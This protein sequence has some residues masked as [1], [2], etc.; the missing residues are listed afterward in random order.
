MFQHV[1]KSIWLG[2]LFSAIALGTVSGIA[3]PQNAFDITAVLIFGWLIPLLATSSDL[4]FNFNYVSP[5][6]TP[7]WLELL[8][9]FY[10]P[11]VAL[12][13]AACVVWTLRRT[14]KRL[15]ALLIAGLLA[16]ASTLVCML[17]GL[18]APSLNS[19][20]TYYSVALAGAVWLNLLFSAVLGWGAGYLI[21]RRGCRMHSKK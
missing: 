12:V 15:D 9:S 18:V 8:T 10:Y 13:M 20:G 19:N 11:L 6:H 3:F 4:N 5:S 7:M 16:C 21:T 14:G 2:T 1:P 17:V